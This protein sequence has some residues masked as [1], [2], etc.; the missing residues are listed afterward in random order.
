MIFFILI[1]PANALP[2]QVLEIYKRNQRAQQKYFT[3]FLE[4]SIRLISSTP[5]F[6]EN[7]YLLLTHK[8]QKTHYGKSKKSSEERR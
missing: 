4:K 2:Q 8:F 1:A 7:V 5:V 6:L 3:T